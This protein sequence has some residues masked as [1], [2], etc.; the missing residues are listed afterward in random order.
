M[1]CLSEL[2]LV[3]G[4]TTTYADRPAL[5]SV[6]VTKVASLDTPSLIVL[7]PCAKSCSYS[8]SSRAV[9]HELC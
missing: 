8:F 9:P 5:H 6:H 3:C 1:E 4:D 7:I 2:L